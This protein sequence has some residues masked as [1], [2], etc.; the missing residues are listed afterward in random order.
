MYNRPDSRLSVRHLL[1]ESH[2]NTSQEAAAAA[3]GG[4]VWRYGNTE[5]HGVIS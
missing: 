1:N 2:L 5:F 3:E 4:N